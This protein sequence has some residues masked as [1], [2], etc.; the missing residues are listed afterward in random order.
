M[1]T[2][3]KIYSLCVYTHAH[4]HM[5]AHTHTRYK[6]PSITIFEDC[7]DNPNSCTV[8]LGF[9]FPPPKLLMGKCL[10]VAGGGAAEQC[11]QPDPAL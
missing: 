9:I 6:R 5:R 11:Q 10:P 4:T 1:L 3:F 2:T 7:F 8:L